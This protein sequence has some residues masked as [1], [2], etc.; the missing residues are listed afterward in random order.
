[1]AS[2]KRRILIPYTTETYLGTLLFYI[3]ICTYMGELESV[4][5]T[6]VLKIAGS[7][8]SASRLARGP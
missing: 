2:T 3:Y 6:V 1:M 8:A 5:E 4:A 7:W